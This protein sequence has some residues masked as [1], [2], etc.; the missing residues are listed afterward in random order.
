MN[1]SLSDWD[2]DLPPEPGEVYKDLVR[3]LTRKSGFGL[4]FVQCIPASADR[5]IKQL[6]QDIPQKNIQVLRLTESIDNLYQ[7]VAEFVKNKRVDILLIKGLE[8]SL[9]KYEKRTFGEITEGKFREL[10]SVPHVLYHLNQQRER[11]RD[12]FH[13]CLVFLLRSFSINYLIHRAPDFFDWRSGVFELPTEP[14]VVESESSRLLLQGNYEEYLQLSAEQKIEKVLEIQDIIA[15]PHQTEARK[16]SLLLELGNLLYSTKEYE[17]TI[18][19]YD[20]AIAIKPDLHEAWYNR[21]N[22]LDDL[23]KYEDAIAS[24]DKA[25]AIKPDKDEAWNNRGYALGNLGKYEDAIVSY[26]KAI[27]I[28]PDD[29]SAWYNR[30]NALGKLGKYED[31]IASY[32]KAI[33]I[34]P[35]KDEAWYNRGVALGKLGKY[36]DAIASYDKAVAIKPDK[37]SAWY[38]RGIALDDLGKYEDAIASYDKAIAIKPDDE[39]SWDIRGYALYK[40]EKLAEAIKSYDKAIELKPEYGNAW[41]NRAIVYGCLGDINTAINNLKQAINLNP[42]YQEMAKTDSDFDLIR[43]DERFVALISETS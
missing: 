32:D 42:E 27:A 41:Y 37:D 9:Y 40:L 8:Y 15:E 25:I 24:Y 18:A 38:N 21:G 43:N 2:D 20:K 1:P 16:A 4:F 35:D 23:G 22:A 7:R 5:L 11:L 28:K 33:A 13:I 19:S 6:P 34:K 10:T 17:A 39:I 29:D 3:A 12:D 26:D 31:A 14:E 30:G 36:E